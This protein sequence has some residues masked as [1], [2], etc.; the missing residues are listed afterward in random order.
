MKTILKIESNHW[1]KDDGTIEHRSYQIWLEGVIALSIYECH[2]SEYWAMNP[3][4]VGDDPY[5]NE[6]RWCEVFRDELAREYYDF[7]EAMEVL[8]NRL[9]NNG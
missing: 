9:E 1:Y 3:S 8:F 2:D 4:H 5:N 6:S 7:G